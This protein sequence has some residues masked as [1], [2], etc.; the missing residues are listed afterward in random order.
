MVFLCSLTCD[1]RYIC[2]VCFIVD[3]DGIVDHLYLNF[4]FTKFVFVPQYLTTI[5]Q[6]YKHRIKSQTDFVNSNLIHIYK[7]E[8]QMCQY[9]KLAVVVSNCNKV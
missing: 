3:I 8:A 6:E 9:G 4:L 1:V 5:L 2:V 7:Q